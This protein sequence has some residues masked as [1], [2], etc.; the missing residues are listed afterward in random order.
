MQLHATLNSFLKHCEEA[1]KIKIVIIYKFSSNK[2]ESSYEILMH[3]FRKKLN[4]EWVLEGEFKLNLLEA[5]TTK[6]NKKILFIN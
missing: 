3:E 5:I 4:I 6:H 1:N 2:F